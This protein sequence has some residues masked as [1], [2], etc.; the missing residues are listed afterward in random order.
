MFLL[1]GFDI[2]GE[3]HM[4]NAIACFVAKRLTCKR[5]PLG[6]KRIRHS[7]MSNAS[8]EVLALG[9]EL[10]VTNGFFSDT[11]NSRRNRLLIH[12]EL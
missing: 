10:L 5:S 6:F 2:Y 8:P 12:N 9:L 11:L 4:Y 1:E 7:R 3:L